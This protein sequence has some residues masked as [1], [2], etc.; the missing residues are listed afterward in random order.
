MLG[1]GNYG[2]KVDVWAIGCMIY[3][4]ITGKHPFWPG[5]AAS[6]EQ[7]KALIC[8][9]QVPDHPNWAAAPS[10]ARDLA[11]Q[12]LALNP[13]TRLSAADAL[14]HPWL[15]AS[16]ESGSAGAAVSANQVSKSVFEG[17]QKYQASSKLKRAILKLLAK[18]ADESRVQSLREQFRA[19]DKHQDGLL[20][21]DELLRG[22]QQCPEFKDL[23]PA[24]IAQLL[25]P[26]LCI[27]KI[28]CTD[29]TAA[30]LARQGFGRAEML[31][32]FRRFDVRREGKISL[33]ALSEV[34]KNAGPASK[35]EA[36]READIGQDGVID[37]E[38]FCIL[39]GG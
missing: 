2:E 25:P 35:L 26:E 19:L 30:L 1:D 4:I 28:S 33:S 12:L 18:E 5:R 7:I 20:T 39:I 21:R 23:T 14:R 29:F 31:A 3:L 32:A 9:G 38:E 36:F 15:K 13:T 22:M 17:L 6:N 34:L 8:S 10:S 16:G 37:F 27:D 11:M 24:D